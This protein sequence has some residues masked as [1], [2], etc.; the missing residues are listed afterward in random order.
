MDAV[1]LA[2]VSAA[3]FGAP[4]NADAVLR[5]EA[6]VEMLAVPFTSPFPAALMKRFYGKDPAK[7]WA[8]KSNNWAPANIVKWADPE[9]DRTYDQALTET[10]PTRAR[11]LWRRLDE[12]AVSSHVVIPLVDRKFVG[13]KAPGLIGPAPRAFDLETWNIAD[14]TLS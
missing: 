9:Y 4:S 3:F 13:A 1:L 8:Q 10:D 2:L 6:D 7:D 12:M 14:W 5:F 11:A